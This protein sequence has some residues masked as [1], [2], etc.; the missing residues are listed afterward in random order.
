M[1][2]KTFWSSKAKTSMPRMWL[3]L[4]LSLSLFAVQLVASHVTHSLALLAAAYHMLYNILSLA[5]CI[6]TIKMSER[7]PKSVANTFGW[8]RF[9]V[10]SMVVNL[11]FLSALNFSIVVEALQ[12]MVHSQ[13]E[14][15]DVMHHPVPVCILTGAA[16]LVNLL[17]IILIGGYTNHQG[18]FLALTPDGDV[19][20]SG[21][22]SEDAVRRGLRR[23]SEA[24]KRVGRCGKQPLPT[25]NAIIRDLA[26][27][28]LVLIT[29]TTVFLNGETYVS[30]IIDPILS[31]V[32]VI[33]V[34]VTSYQFMLQAGQILLQTTPDYID[35]QE[36]K[37][38]L[39]D[40]F[41]SLTNIHE[42]HV[43]ML[44]PS[45]IYATAHLIFASKDLYQRDK[46]TIEAFFNDMGITQVTL[47]PEFTKVGSS[48]GTETCTLP[49]SLESC[50]DKGCCSNEISAQSPAMDSVDP[51]PLLSVVAAT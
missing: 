44:T 38:E 4:A 42:M 51:T 47:Q 16:L 7:A 40:A 13:H 29:A 10:V 27:S 32:S 21:S 19:V 3:V 9:E 48:S 30:L 33:V 12:T 41:P 23:R 1:A 2:K 45:R 6:A 26:S 24:N 49:C 18:S 34:S 36:F 50:K 8:T 20:L 46:D 5:G 11:L 28:V 37:T 35:V 43:W 22:A 17:C 25:V 31:I 39:M 15:G 14:H